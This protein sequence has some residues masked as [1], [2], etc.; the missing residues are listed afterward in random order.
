MSSH[1]SKYLQSMTQRQRRLM[2][3]IRSREAAFQSSFHMADSILKPYQSSKDPHLQPYFQK[4]GSTGKK[5]N[6]QQASGHSHSKS[7]PKHRDMIEEI[8]ATIDIPSKFLVFNSNPASLEFHL[9]PSHIRPRAQ[10]PLTARTRR[11]K[12]HTITAAL[13]RHQK[14]SKR[15]TPKRHQSSPNDP[16]GSHSKPRHHIPLLSPPTPSG[17]TNQMPA[18]PT[19]VAAPSVFAMTR[20][21]LQLKATRAT[22]PS[23]R[24]VRPQTAGAR[25]TTPYSP[26]R[27]PHATQSLFSPRPAHTSRSQT[28][29]KP[30]RPRT[31]RPAPRRPR[32]AST[33]GAKSGAS[34]RRSAYLSVHPSNRP[35]SSRPRGQ[36]GPRAYSLSHARLLG[37]FRLLAKELD[38][39]ASEQ[40]VLEGPDF[41]TPQ[42]IKQ[43]SS[44]RGA[45]INSR[46]LITSREALLQHAS[47]L[48]DQT[49]AADQPQYGQ[50][51]PSAFE[52]RRELS[53]TLLALREVTLELCDAVQHIHTTCRKPLSVPA[54]YATDSSGGIDSNY[55]L[56]VWKYD[57]PSTAPPDTAEQGSQEDAA[58][59]DPSPI[60][61]RAS[62]PQLFAAAGF[63]SRRMSASGEAEESTSTVEAFYAD[64]TRAGGGHSHAALAMLLGTSLTERSVPGLATDLANPLPTRW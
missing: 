55:L 34:F 13:A 46:E 29:K 14:K 17:E 60:Y 6:R 57:G 39:P 18:S 28:S 38:I 58:V 23:P 21:P 22:Q 12:D 56:K 40:S 37:R 62:L 25:L 35:R 41:L 16:A 45:L 51:E 36:S 43:L 3:S 2:S 4:L 48:R 1:S 31:A 42:Y 44:V 52:L 7:Q 9:H 59:T 20:R 11:S 49:L 33:R 63:P 64:V 8:P 47:S 53:R 26:S 19:T 61:S 54:L 24:K 10:R 15:S 50:R 5:R 27:L 32:T 30:R